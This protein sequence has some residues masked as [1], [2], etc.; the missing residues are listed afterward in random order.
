MIIKILKMLLGSM[1]CPTEMGMEIFLVSCVADMDL[2]ST[3]PYF[4]IRIVIRLL[5]WH[6][7]LKI[8]WKIK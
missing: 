4:P 1:D 5:G 6:L 2:L 7:L 8:R 3:T